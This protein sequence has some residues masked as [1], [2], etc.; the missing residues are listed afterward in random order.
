MA[1]RV[2]LAPFGGEGEGERVARLPT[3]GVRGDT[4]PR[5]R[6]REPQ[7]RNDWTTARNSA[8]FSIIVQWPQPDSRCSRESG[9]KSTS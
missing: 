1:V 6:R 2:A 8:V 4:L 5:A 9:S 7:L 3:G